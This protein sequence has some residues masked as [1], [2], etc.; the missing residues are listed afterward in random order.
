MVQEGGREGRQEGRG[1][2]KNK[3]WYCIKELMVIARQEQQWKV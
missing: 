1:E 3:E 2:K